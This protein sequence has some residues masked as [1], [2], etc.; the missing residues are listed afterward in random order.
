[1]IYYHYFC[2]YINKWENFNE[3]RVI[4]QTSKVEFDFAYPGQK[5][6]DDFGGK[7]YVSIENCSTAL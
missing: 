1:V 4:L 3:I 5:I 7:F 6:K 2:T